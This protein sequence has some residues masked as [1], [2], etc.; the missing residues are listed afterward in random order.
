MD[1]AGRPRLGGRGGGFRD[2]AGRCG[3]SMR[4]SGRAAAGVVSASG[5]SGDAAR[6]AVGRPARTVY[7]GRGAGVASLH[8]RRWV[9]GLGPAPGRALSRSP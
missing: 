8:R 6:W 9:K 2:A 7:S 1:P 3:A 5:P 4:M